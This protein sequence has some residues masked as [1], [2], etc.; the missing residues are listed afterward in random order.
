ME[1]YTTLDSMSATPCHTAMSF[2]FPS[3]LVGE[4]QGEEEVRRQVDSL[5]PIVTPYLY[6]VLKSHI[7]TFVGFEASTEMNLGNL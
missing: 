7:P 1:S 6:L 4:D 5:P 3:L 2:G